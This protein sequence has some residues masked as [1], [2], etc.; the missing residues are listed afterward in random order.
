MVNSFHFQ[1]PI[2]PVKAFK[3]R[4]LLVPIHLPLNPAGLLLYSGESTP[5]TS[6]LYVILEGY[7]SHHQYL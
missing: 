2:G 6:R 7:R 3:Q 1:V 4:K 5:G